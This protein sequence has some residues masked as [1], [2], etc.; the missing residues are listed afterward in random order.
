MAED[1]ANARNGKETNRSAFSGLVRMVSLNNRSRDGNSK[2][3]NRS[4]SRAMSTASSS[5]SSSSSA[6]YRNLSP[7]STS[8]ANGRPGV[9]ASTHEHTVWGPPPVM[10]TSRTIEGIELMDKNTPVIVNG[11]SSSESSSSSNAG[12]SPRKS[13]IQQR[14]VSTRAP[15]RTISPIPIPNDIQELPEIE[16]PERLQPRRSIDSL[17]PTTHSHIPLPAYSELEFPSRLDEGTLQRTSSMPKISPKGH[18]RHSLSISSTARAKPAREVSSSDTFSSPYQGFWTVHRNDEDESEGVSEAN[19]MRELFKESKGPLWAVSRGWKKGIFL[20]FDEAEKQTRNFP[21]P[22]IRQFANVDE[23]IEFLELSSKSPAI[24]TD[25]D[26]DHATRFAS[27]ALRKPAFQRQLSLQS[28]NQSNSELN[29]VLRSPST[30]PFLSRAENLQSPWGASRSAS[31]AILPG[32]PL[33]VSIERAEQHKMKS[34]EGEISSDNGFLTPRSTMEHERLIAP[35]ITTIFSCQDLDVSIDLYTKAMAFRV[36]E[37][38]RQ[39]EQVSLIYKDAQQASLTLRKN[40][41]HLENE[42]MPLR[43][44]SCMITM[45]SLEVEELHSS[46]TQSLKDMQQMSAFP[47]KCVLSGIDVKVRVEVLLLLLS[48][49]KL[50]HF[51]IYSSPGHPLNSPSQTETAT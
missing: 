16:S 20:T 51:L 27:T 17:L 43:T 33:L 42:A 29:R 8:K 24:T 10:K 3:L 2:G 18:Q 7:G 44:S 39:E 46:I 26:K 9:T 23:A 4:L 15:Y 19:R 36:L 1:I 50:S 38:A 34:A 21:G 32:T 13:S 45:S 31:H 11:Q 35:S 6:G 5:S 12:L 48:L 30:N 41:S 49:I 28:T 25:E 22:L 40:Q 37:N 47:H 14:R